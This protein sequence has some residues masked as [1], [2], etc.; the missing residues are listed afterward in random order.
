MSLVL[1]PS[2]WIMPRRMSSPTHQ[3]LEIILKGNWHQH[4][5]TKNQKN[6]QWA[7]EDFEISF[8]LGKQKFS[9]V[10]LIWEKQS[11]FIQAL[12][13]LFK[14]QLEKGVEHQL[15]REIEIQ[16]HLRHPNILRL[17]RYFHDSIRVY[18]ILEYSPLGAVY[19]EL[20]KLP[21]FDKQRTAIYI[22]ELANSVLLSFKGSYS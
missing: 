7:L 11:K 9:N 15:R 22:T 2:H 18:L 6:Q 5:K 20:Q 19:R 17:H 12:K 8:P 16:S 13:V 1:S 10:Y 14:A 3:P 4:R 21:R